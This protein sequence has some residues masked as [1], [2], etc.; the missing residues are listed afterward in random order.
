M[1]VSA[2]LCSFEAIHE[3]CQ[4]HKASL[5]LLRGSRTSVVMPMAR[6]SE[7]DRELSMAVAFAC[8]D[9]YSSMAATLSQRHKRLFR[10]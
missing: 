8:A 4:R 7:A 3:V 1:L 9:D 6:I 5:S 10:C 2:L